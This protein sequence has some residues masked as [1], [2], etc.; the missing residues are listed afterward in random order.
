MPIAGCWLSFLFGVIESDVATFGGA[1]ADGVLDRNDENASVTDL[2]GL[3]GFDDSLYGL[4]CI[5]V[6]IR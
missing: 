4:F 6:V 5:F 2:S 3:C 1:D